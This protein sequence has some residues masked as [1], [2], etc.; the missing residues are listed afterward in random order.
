MGKPPPSNTKKYCGH[1][2]TKFRGMVAARAGGAPGTAVTIGTGFIPRRNILNHFSKEKRRKNPPF[3]P[4]ALQMET[5]VNSEAVCLQ[6]HRRHSLPVVELR[7]LCKDVGVYRGPLHAGL[8]G[9]NTWREAAPPSGSTN[10]APTSTDHL[11]QVTSKLT[12]CEPWTGSTALPS[13]LFPERQ[14]TTNGPT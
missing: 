9:P 5:I 6:W 10:T 14:C 4:C 11:P 7:T 2:G 3:Y 13:R 1:A 8:L 12:C